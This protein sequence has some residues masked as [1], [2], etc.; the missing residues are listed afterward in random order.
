M[1]DSH[2]TF[3]AGFLTGSIQ[4]IIGHPL[5]TLKVLLQT[6]NKNN[7]KFTGLYN[8]LKYPLLTQSCVSSVLFGSFNYFK[9]YNLNN[10]NAGICSGFLTGFI[11]TPIEFLK[12]KEQ[13]NNKIIFKKLNYNLF[14]G[15]KPTIVRECIGNGI[16]FYSYYE[17]K[18]NNYSTIFSG[19]MAGCLSWLFSYPLDVIKSRIQVDS[20]LSINKAYHMGNLFKGLTPCLLRA[21]LINGVGFYCLENIKK[22]L[23]NF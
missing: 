7:I 9:N 1:H 17:L 21:T 20:S 8:G 4:T 23:D 3:L 19:G 12:I 10:L 5:D 14:T 16:Y 22:I 18:K 13:T 11:L 6:N 15:L 2:N